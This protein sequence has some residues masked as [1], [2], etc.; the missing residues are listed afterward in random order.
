MNG[1]WIQ[2]RK[3][4]ATTTTEQVQS[5][6]FTSLL[7]YE[8]NAQQK[9]TVAHFETIPFPKAILHFKA[10]HL[11]THFTTVKHRVISI[12]SI[13]FRI[14][15]IARNKNQ[16]RYVYN[17]SVVII[18]W[19][20]RRREKTQRGHSNIVMWVFD[21]SCIIMSMKF[22]M[23]RENVLLSLLLLS[24]G[25]QRYVVHTL[26]NTITLVKCQELKWPYY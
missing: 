12:Y 19:T 6:Y 8:L 2:T 17:I 10:L 21:L 3:K 24:N 9:M 11:V 5:L 13:Y 4:R 23:P 15:L 25:I 22:Q 14:W 18:P 16:L 26:L 1:I 7:I 20:R